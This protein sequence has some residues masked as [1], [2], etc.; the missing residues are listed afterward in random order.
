MKS[1]ETSLCYAHCCSCSVF[2]SFVAVP[3]MWPVLKFLFDPLW[4]I[5]KACWIIPVPA[6]RIDW[7]V[8]DWC[9]SGWLETSRR[10]TDPKQS[11]KPSPVCTRNDLLWCIIGFSHWYNGY[12]AKTQRIS[13]I[14]LLYVKFPTRLCF[15]S[16]LRLLLLNPAEQHLWI[17]LD[18]TTAKRWTVSMNILKI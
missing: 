15:I 13:L 6:W 2:W 8:N 11:T 7:L 18:L 17:F 10:S 16:R 5:W 14:G 12:K 9:V 3:W 4:G 1:L